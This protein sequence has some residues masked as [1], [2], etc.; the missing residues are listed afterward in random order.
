MN[1]KSLNKNSM[2]KSPTGES[3]MAQ[4]NPD[5]KSNTQLEQSKPI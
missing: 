2:N 4:P 1:D 3:S 5:L